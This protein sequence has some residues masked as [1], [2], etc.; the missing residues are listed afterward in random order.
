MHIAISMSNHNFAFAHSTVGVTFQ[1]QLQ[2]LVDN[3]ANSER[4][5]DINRP[6]GL[7]EF[8]AICVNY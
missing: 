4:D 5:S 1:N 6:F 8:R 3:V 7:L 2:R